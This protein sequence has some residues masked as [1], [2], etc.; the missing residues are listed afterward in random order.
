VAEAGVQFGQSKT[1]VVTTLEA[2]RSQLESIHRKCLQSNRATVVTITIPPDNEDVNPF[3]DEIA[4]L[5]VGVG[6]PSRAFAWMG[7]YA[8][9]DSLRPYIEDIWYDYGGTP[10][11]YSPFRTRVT[12]EIASNIAA[13][14][15]SSAG[16]RVPTGVR[17]VELDE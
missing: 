9:K 12:F 17:W 16:I 13:Q 11:A 4:I 1:S 14:F 8:V 15:F 3:E 10:T 2:L 6:H 5:Q 7:P